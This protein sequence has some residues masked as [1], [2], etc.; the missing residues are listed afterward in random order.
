MGLNQRQGTIYYYT[1]DECGKKSEESANKDDAHFFA[2]SSCYEISDSEVLCY[3]CAFEK[4][5][6]TRWGLNRKK[7]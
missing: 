7:Q 2:V 6:S 3:D 4:R 1:C 5:R